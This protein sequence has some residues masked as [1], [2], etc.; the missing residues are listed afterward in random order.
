MLLFTWARTAARPIAE[1]KRGIGGFAAN[2]ADGLV[3]WVGHTH[4]RSSSMTGTCE[5]G[6]EL[7]MHTAN[8]NGALVGMR[9]LLF[10]GGKK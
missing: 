2:A 9:S 4:L 3:P 5:R 7:A 8:R 10:S 1:Q 6:S